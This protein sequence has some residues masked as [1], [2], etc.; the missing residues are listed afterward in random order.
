VRRICGEAGFT[1]VEML[2]VMLIMGVVMTGITTLFVQGSNAEVDMNQ[3]FQAQLNARLALDRLRREAHCASTA[4]T[5]STTLTLTVAT[6]CPGSGG[7]T[8][9]K[10]CLLSSGGRYALFRQTGAGACA[11]TSN[12]YADYV[13]YSASNTYFALQPNSTATLAKIYVCIPVNI[14]SASLRSVDTYGLRDVL[15]MR[16]ST[17]TGTPGTPVTFPTTCPG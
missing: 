15:V 7:T 11:T 16:N 2:T 4:T 13:V 9:I 12:K 1:L 10:W 5:S 3:R 6:T 8:S 17:R 14:K